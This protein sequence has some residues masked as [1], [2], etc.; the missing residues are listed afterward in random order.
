M[1]LIRVTHRNMSVRDYLQEQL[2]HWRKCFPTTLT[3][4]ILK[5]RWNFI[6]PSP[7]A[8]VTCLLSSE[9]ASWAFPHPSTTSEHLCTKTSVG[10]LWGP[11]LLRIQEG[12]TQGTAFHRALGGGSSLCECT[13]WLAKQ[14]QTLQIR[15]REPA[16][17]WCLL[18]HRNQTLAQGRT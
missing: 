12:N 17:M 16:A 3:A 5:E 6:S 13:V 7:L 18:N 10:L 1:D 14:V 8:T 4:F 15:Y 11:K 9:W 2:C